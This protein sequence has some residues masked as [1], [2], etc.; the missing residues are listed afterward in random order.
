MNYADCQALETLCS[1]SLADLIADYGLVEDSRIEVQVTA[2]NFYGTSDL[3]AI[4]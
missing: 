1:I 3:S 2:T 4:D